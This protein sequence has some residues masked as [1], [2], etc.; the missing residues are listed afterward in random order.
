MV[1]TELKVICAADRTLIVGWRPVSDV[2]GPN[3]IWQVLKIDDQPADFGNHILGT[4]I[5]TNI[6]REK[7]GK[8]ARCLRSQTRKC[9]LSVR[10]QS[11]LS[12]QED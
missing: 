11:D 1:A 3:G 12:P 9:D 7:I 2:G 4:G 10:T 8:C 5:V 6:Q